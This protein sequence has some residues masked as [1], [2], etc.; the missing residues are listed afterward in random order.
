M[1]YNKFAP[2]WQLAKWHNK[3]I[4]DVTTHAYVLFPVASK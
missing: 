3:I 1:Q 2:T 4:V